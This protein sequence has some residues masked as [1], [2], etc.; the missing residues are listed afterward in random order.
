MTW[1]AMLPTFFQSTASPGRTEHKNVW[2]KL[3]TCIKVFCEDLQTTEMNLLVSMKQMEQTVRNKLQVLLP[4]PITTCMFYLRVLR[5]CV[6][7]PCL[8]VQWYTLL[9]AR[10]TGFH[11]AGIRF[12][13]THAPVL[14]KAKHVAALTL[15]HVVVALLIPSCTLDLM[16]GVWRGALRI[17]WSPSNDVVSTTSG[18]S[19]CFVSLIYNNLRCSG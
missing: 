18:F 3:L 6:R 14:P 17:S 1:L 4:W 9:N 13:L 5:K 7:V 16:S 8:A 11:F 10:V 19:C 15:A 12:V 2:L